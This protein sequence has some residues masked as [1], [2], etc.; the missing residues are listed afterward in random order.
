MNG[1]SWFWIEFFFWYVVGVIFK[2]NSICFIFLERLYNI[3]FLLLLLEWDGGGIGRSD[4]GS[5][6]R[7]RRI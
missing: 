1:L 2:M 4:C 5:D 3:S 6:S 7:V